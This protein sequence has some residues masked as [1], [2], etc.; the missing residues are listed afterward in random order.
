MSSNK[1]HKHWSDRVHESVVSRNKSGQ[2]NLV[3]KGGAEEIKFPYFGSV[4]Q[5]K[6]IYH[7]GKIQDGEILLEVN[8]QSVVGLTLYDLNNL[9]KQ[10]R[11]PVRFKTVKEGQT[12][13]KDLKLY[14]SQRFNKGTVDHQLQ[15]AI[16]DNLYL[17]T[18]PC[19]TRKLRVGEID[20][21]D[22]TFLTVEQFQELEKSGAL[23]ESGIYEG[24]YYGTPKPPP[25]PLSPP[26]VRRSNSA[27]D[28]PGLHPS[29]DGK[30]KRNRSNIE[31]QTSPSVSSPRR[32]NFF[33]QEAEEN[34]S[35]SVTT[36]DSSTPSTPNGDAT[37]DKDSSKKEAGMQ[38]SLMHSEK[39]LGP[40]PEGWEMAQTE[41]GDF[42]FIDHIGK[43]TSW[44]DP[45]LDGSSQLPYGWEKIDDSQF[46]TYYVD[47]IEKK[48]Q[49]PNPVLEAKGNLPPEKQSSD[50]HNAVHSDNNTQ[51]SQNETSDGKDEIP[52]KFDFTND[53]NELNGVS[54]HV[55]IEKS[56][57]GFGFTI[58]G[59]DDPEEFLQIK[60]VVPDGPAAR[61]GNIEQGDVIV[62]VNDTCV[63][64]WTHPDV[65]KL[66]QAIPVGQIVTL[67]LCRGYP[68]LVDSDD[69]STNIVTTYA[70]GPDDKPVEEFERQ[71][72]MLNSQL[73]QNEDGY[74][75]GVD[76][77]N[78]NFSCPSK[79]MPDISNQN[80]EA[81]YYD[82]TAPTSNYIPHNNIYA[83]S[84][85]LGNLP[86]PLVM[87]VIIEK[88][89]QG[90]GF[91][92]A[93]SPQGQRVKQILDAPRC[94]ELMASDIL[95]EINGTAVQN[96]PH[97]NVVQ[98]LKDCPGN[99]AA[100]FVIQRGPVMIYDQPTSIGARQNYVNGSHHVSLPQQA[101][102]YTSHAPG[103]RGRMKRS[104][105]EPGLGSENG[106]VVSAPPGSTLGPPV[107]T[108][109][110]NA[111]LN[112]YRIKHAVAAN[113]DRPDHVM[114]PT[115]SNYQPY[116]GQS[117]YHDPYSNFPPQDNY[118]D[119][120]VVLRREESGFGFRILGGNAQ[121]ETVTIGAIV[122]KGAADKEGTLRTGDELLTVDGQKVTRMGHNQVIA[123][124]GNAARNAVVKLGIRRRVGATQ[125]MNRPSRGPMSRQI[126]SRPS[127]RG[128]GGPVPVNS[129]RIFDI[130]IHRREHEGFGFVIISS[131]KT[132]D[133]SFQAPHKIGRIIDGSPAARCEHLRVGDRILAVNNVDITH[134]H[135][136][137]IVNLIKDSG[138][139]I[140]LRVLPLDAEEESE[141]G[142]QQEKR[143]YT[144]IQL[145]RSQKGFGISIRGGR[146]YNMPLYVL[147]VARDG[148]AADCSDIRVGDILIEING[149]S[150]IDIP[151][152]QAI[153]LIKQGGTSVRLVLKKGDGTVPEIDSKPS[154]SMQ[155]L[156]SSALSATDR[157]G[158]YGHLLSDKQH[159]V[160]SGHP[161]KSIPPTTSQ[162]ASGRGGRHP[163]ISVRQIRRRAN[164]SGQVLPEDPNSPPALRMRRAITPNPAQA[165]KE[166]VI[167]PS[168]SDVGARINESIKLN[169]EWIRHENST[170]F[171]DR[172]SRNQ[173]APLSSNRNKDLQP[174]AN[175]FATSPTSTT[176]T[177]SPVHS[178]EN[179]LVPSTDSTTSLTESLENEDPSKKNS[180][181]GYDEADGGKSAVNAEDK[182][183]KKKKLKSGKSK[184]TKVGLWLSPK[185]K[186]K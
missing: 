156:S 150:T 80:Y 90:F 186:Q 87:Q 49:F 52:N 31:Q 27:N 174:K 129:S 120:M 29:S 130:V 139:A 101:Y 67:Q 158:R 144:V 3:I 60:S 23:L 86:A 36:K 104:Q 159:S 111:L 118:V 39:V 160:S 44:L 8:D 93:D 173:P 1:K 25:V 99:S 16:R 179:G 35:L 91:T 72:Q 26:M 100:I 96:M 83:R 185:K 34:K 180:I 69:P 12:L 37:T 109:P 79:S 41:S 145:Q 142:M 147:R 107:S 84:G 121:D 128:P 10:A 106:S 45:R 73:E 151:H 182:K 126:N 114:P 50:E 55:P 115:S 123:L 43:K 13:V 152:S 94:H 70:I 30:R 171:G 5:E 7:S 75:P 82:D 51:I 38:E 66:F 105:T 17:R 32:N 11:D 170:D 64:G 125:M 166:P 176:S 149:H 56:S 22:Y 154:G 165:P 162:P 184:S 81:G 58:V 54:H 85:S 21:V 161:Q 108:H 116:G 117:L 124:M 127:S 143:D 183:G 4:K 98:I 122:A 136:G 155:S 53:P 61:T 2:L 77:A 24:N 62:K 18:L 146:E 48:T 138:F 14:L 157:V 140:A 153:N 134:L 113:M 59:G 141:T 68:L 74:Y 172:S 177:I 169:K 57:R 42:Y 97:N 76:K 33:P 133:G 20:G 178:K 9:I 112:E 131:V 119:L 167:S 89:D 19:T 95:L 132:S 63:L 148:P 65:V 78:S 47:H 163:Q 135:H 164:S 28:L 102:P 103:Y 46:G 6:V 110:V 88:G 175:S 168:G 181:A 92:I 71:L 15:A 137:Q 40:L